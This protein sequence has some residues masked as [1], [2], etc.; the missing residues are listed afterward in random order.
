MVELV[1]YFSDQLCSSQCSRAR[2]HA[3]PC[4]A[5]HRMNIM[6]RHYFVIID[7]WCWWLRG[8]MLDEQ[9]QKLFF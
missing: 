4:L 9:Q 2:H 7:L 3:F 1:S 5:R 6:E 8:S